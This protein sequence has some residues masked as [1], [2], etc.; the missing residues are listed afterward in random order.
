MDKKVI[1]EEQFKKLV[2]SEAKKIFSEEENT[3]TTAKD[4]RRVT[5]D[6]VESLINE[7][8]NMNTS[9]SSILDAANDAVS[10]AAN[11]APS[12]IDE[13][14]E[15]WKPNQDRDLD[16]IEHNKKKNIMHVNESEK[17]KWKRM[18]GYEIPNDEE[19]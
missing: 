19:R 18:L 6:N 13:S 11:D 10:D 5:F 2:I 17:D 1:N 14:A 7:M 9:I 15:N 8:E 3:E 4:K 16:A 12:T